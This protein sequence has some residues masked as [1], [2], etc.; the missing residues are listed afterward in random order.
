[1]MIL[2]STNIYVWHVKTCSGLQTKSHRMRSRG[3]MDMDVGTRLWKIGW[4]RRHDL[5]D[6]QDPPIRR[7]VGVP[8]SSRTSGRVENI[9]QLGRGPYRTVIVRRRKIRGETEKEENSWP[10]FNLVGLFALSHIQL[11]WFF[12][13]KIVFFSHNSSVRTVFFSLFQTN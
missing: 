4:G 6:N 10:S 5:R 8:S 2:A 11:V 13:V 9:I 3:R 12:L 7:G 1:M